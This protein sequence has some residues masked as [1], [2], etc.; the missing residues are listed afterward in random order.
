MVRRGGEFLKNLLVHTKIVRVRSDFKSTNPI[1]EPSTIRSVRAM[2]IMHAHEQHEQHNNFQRSYERYV[3]ININNP[4]PPPPPPP[5]PPSPHITLHPSP[6]RRPPPSPSTLYSCRLPPLPLHRLQRIIVSYTQPTQ[7]SVRELRAL[8]LTPHLLTS[9]CTESKRS[10]FPK[11]DA[12][13][14]TI[15]DIVSQFLCNRRFNRR[16]IDFA[17]VR[18]TVVSTVAK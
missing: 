16:N 3:I 7:H 13:K 12:I 2:H 10:C 15:A 1:S 8:G 6:L 4:P 9:R 18:L 11:L 14:N 5:H 17:K